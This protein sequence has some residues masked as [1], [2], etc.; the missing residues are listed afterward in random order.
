M[1]A[2]TTFYT[3]LSW[4]GPFLV[5]LTLLVFIH[6]LGHY[7]VARRAGVKIDVFSIGFGPELF[8]FNDCQGTRWKFSLV[9][10][11]GYVKMFGDANAASAPDVKEQKKMSPQE[12]SW[13]LE[14]K[15]V[16]QRMAVCGAGPAA[17]MGL[18]FALLIIVYG[19]VGKPSDRPVIGDVAPQSAAVTAGLQVGDDIRFINGVPVETYKQVQKMINQSP[20][21][22]LRVTYERKG[23]VSTVDVVPHAMVVTPTT[24]IGVLGIRPLVESIRVWQVP[25]VAAQSV[26]LMAKDILSFLGSL[27]LK[28]ADASQLGSVMSIAKMSKDS[29][30]NGFFSVLSFMVL[31]SLNLGL[32][33]LFPIPG[34]DGGHLFFYL[35]EAIRGKP[36]SARVQDISF[37]IGFGIL[38]VVMVFTMWNDVVRFSVIKTVMGIFK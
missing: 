31:L 38:I 3:I 16:W 6:E 22:P 15:T 17:N 20:N 5:V 37:K 18:A 29:F 19:F 28:K 25:F 13:T 1:T 33:N 35:I 23:E 34:L 10:L 7:L 2:I 4:V 32:I 8:G 27:V 12:R 26:G 21:K 11:G 30:E 24:T 36:V 14:S 9:P